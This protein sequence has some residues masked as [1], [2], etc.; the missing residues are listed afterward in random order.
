MTFGAAQKII[1]TEKLPKFGIDAGQDEAQYMLRTKSDEWFY[2]SEYR[3]IARVSETLEDNKE[4]LLLTRK[5]Y[6]PIEKG[7]LVSVI[8]GCRAPVGKIQ[9]IVA[10]YSPGLPVKKAEKSS[11]S[12]GVV[13][14]EL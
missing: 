2:E 12:Y 4:R 5:N 7:W 6:L 8:A 13:V 1:Y 10:Q 11:D 14:P 9:E 3:I